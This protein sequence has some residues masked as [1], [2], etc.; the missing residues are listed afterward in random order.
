MKK[1]KLWINALVLA[2]CLLLG[3]GQASVYGAAQNAAQAP[4]DPNAAAADPNAAAADP[5]AAPA[6]PNAPADAAEAPKDPNAPPDSYN[7]EVQSDALPGWPT[8]PQV[9]AETAILMD[10]E[11]GE[12]LYAKGIDEKR[13]PASTTKIMTV[14]IA[15]ENSALTDQVTFSAEAVNGIEPGSTHIGIKPG[16]ILTM[17]QSLYAILLASANEVSSGVAEFV[18]GSIPDFVN[19]MNARAEKLGCKNTHFVNA[20]GLHDPEHYTT[21]RDLANIA[22]EA[23]K[24]ETFRKIIGTEYYIEP[25]T[26]ITDEER[27]LNNHHKMLVSGDMHY[28]G[29]LG[30]KTGYTSDAGNSLVTYAQRNGMYLISVV[31]ADNAVYQYPDTAALLDYGFSNFHKVVLAQK[32]EVECLKPLPIEHYLYNL[33]KA[34]MMTRFTDTATAD[35]PTDLPVEKLTRKTSL[36]K[37]IQTTEYYLG[38]Q[39]LSSSHAEVCPTLTL[40]EFLAAAKDSPANTANTAGAAAQNNT[41]DSASAGRTPK[42]SSSSLGE[43]FQ[44]L[45]YNFR[46]MP[47]WKYPALIFLLSAVIFY[48]VLLIIKIKRHRKK[49][50]RN[51]KKKK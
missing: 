2:S 15:I 22:R 6:D 40:P 9:A 27:W 47:T 50:T 43:F 48:I 37:K 33:T 46:N 4:A 13:Y 14:L 45:R 21:A 51:K 24:N 44:E 12:I 29:C 31:L 32:G 1:T 28:D 20:N 35:L 7:W 11:T 17:E 34:K 26:N 16:E 25:K 19:M 36:E 18:G 41:A 23:F 38:E 5:N 10:A 49:K 39:L 30:G 42:T 3:S 8:G